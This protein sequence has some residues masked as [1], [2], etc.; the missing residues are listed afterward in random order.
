METNEL[1][2]DLKKL[3]ADF[4]RLAID[5]KYSLENLWGI[6]EHKLQ[7]CEEPEENAIYS[8]QTNLTAVTKELERWRSKYEA[9]ATGYEMKVKDDVIFTHNLER[10]LIEHQGKTILRQAEQID[11]LTKEVEQWKE[12]YENSMELR[13]VAI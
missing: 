3:K 1:P 8:L 6:V 2:E 9:I 10:G 5:Q 7:S 13:T 11:S 12:R 4:F